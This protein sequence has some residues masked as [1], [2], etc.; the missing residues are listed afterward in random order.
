MKAIRGYDRNQVL[1]GTLLGDG[2]L[3]VSSH[4][5]RKASLRIKHKKSNY[6][7]IVWLSKFLR[8][9]SNKDPIIREE[10]GYKAYKKHIYSVLHIR[11]SKKLYYMWKRFYKINP[12]NK[13]IYTS[14]IK[15]IRN[16]IV[17]SIDK[18]ALATWYM[19]DGSISIVRSKK[20]KKVIR[21]IIE[22]STEGFTK[23]ENQL[24][25]GRLKK[26][27]HLNPFLIGRNRNGKILY[28]IRLN[29]NDALKFIEIVYPY[30]IQIP[31]MRYKVKIPPNVELFI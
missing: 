25:I 15:V 17:N 19:D 26:K 2:C 5:L 27:F 11:T 4:N 30:V 31:S 6:D 16:N 12:K 9:F 1:I 21:I 3:I 14:G 20:T 7:Y 28:S 18:L 13:S 8:Q 22:L 24:L 23:Y 29:T 10:H